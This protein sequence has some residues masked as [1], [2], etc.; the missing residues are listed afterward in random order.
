MIRQTN[1][2]D[3]ATALLAEQQREILAVLKEIRDQK[4]PMSGAEMRATLAPEDWADAKRLRVKHESLENIFE[5]DAKHKGY[6]SVDEMIRAE[7]PMHQSEETKLAIEQMHA[8]AKPSIF[9]TVKK[10]KGD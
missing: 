2:T 5:F 4:K 3:F 1:S 10:R 8:N 9:E 6:G 7:A